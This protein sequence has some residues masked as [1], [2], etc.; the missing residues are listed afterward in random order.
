MCAA[1]KHINLYDK[2]VPVLNWLYLRIE[3][4]LENFENQFEY[5]VHLTLRCQKFNCC[6]RYAVGGLEI[7]SNKAIYML[8]TR[9]WLMFNHYRA[10]SIHLG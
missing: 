10:M 3:H 9:A 7:N 5:E 6:G 1:N 2:K 8:H 4:N